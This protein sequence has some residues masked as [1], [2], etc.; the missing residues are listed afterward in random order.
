MLASWEGSVSLIAASV[1]EYTVL[2]TN[3]H[4]LEPW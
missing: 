2:K 3:V 1:H 4:S